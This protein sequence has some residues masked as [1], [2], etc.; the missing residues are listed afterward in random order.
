MQTI[1]KVKSTSALNSFVV[2]PLKTIRNQNLPRIDEDYINNGAYLK[3]LESWLSN[4]NV[5]LFKKSVLKGCST[6]FQS[7]KLKISKVQ[8][9][10]ERQG[11]DLLKLTIS[12]QFRY[13]QYHLPKSIYK[14]IE[15]SR[16]LMKKSIFG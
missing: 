10:F 9:V 13:K 7:D 4:E 6:F 11:F 15:G 8:N 16:F 2:P 14:N 1:S 5:Y 12:Y 3:N